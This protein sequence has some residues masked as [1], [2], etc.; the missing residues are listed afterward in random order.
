LQ[1]KL[2]ASLSFFE[3]SDHFSCFDTEQKN[4]KA[5]GYDHEFLMLYLKT[6]SNYCLFF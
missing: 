3:F 4:T 2:S 1:I 5:F 6:I